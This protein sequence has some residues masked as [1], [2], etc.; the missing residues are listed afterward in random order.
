[1]PDKISTA[2]FLAALIAFQFKHLIADFLL[3]TT[4][5]ANGKEQ[6]QGWLAPLCAHVAIHAVGTALI[7]AF[8]APAYI[9][10][11]A[12][13]FV[14]HFLI[15]RAKGLAGRA[16]NADSTKTV[17]WWLIGVDQTLHHLTHMAFALLI[18]IVRG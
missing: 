16:L 6:P 13:D 8:L 3:Q 4:W 1:M 10:M 14:V 11:A 7:F 15:D 12:V 9:A 18:V 17:F 2:L 5:M